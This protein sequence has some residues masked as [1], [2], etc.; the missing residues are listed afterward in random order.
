MATH[1]SL[2]AWK[3]PWMEEPGK[4]QSMGLW[5]RTQLSDFTSLTS[6]FI[7]AEGNGNPL[8]YSRE[9]HGQRSMAGHGQWGHRGSDMTEVTKQQQHT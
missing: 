9:S 4:L 2:L 6:Y 8:Q 3:I 5:S 7:I 1:S